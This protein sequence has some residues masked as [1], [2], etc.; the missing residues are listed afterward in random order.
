M[1]A[2]TVENASTPSARLLPLRRNTVPNMRLAMMQKP[3]EEAVHTVDQVQGIDDAHACEDRERH[4]DR[5]GQAPHA[6]Q[7][8]EVVQTVVAREDQQAHGEDLRHETRVEGRR[9]RMSSIVPV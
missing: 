1:S 5:A 6:P 9:F 8:V 3:D 4:R 2:P 7:T